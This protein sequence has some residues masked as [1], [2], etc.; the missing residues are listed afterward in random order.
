MI[1]VVVIALYISA[2]LSLIGSPVDVNAENLPEMIVSRFKLQIRENGKTTDNYIIGRLIIFGSKNAPQIVWH[3]VL[4][5]T[6]HKLKITSVKSSYADS[7]TGE[8]KNLIIGD[9]FFSFNFY[10]NPRRSMMIVGRRREPDKWTE[11][12]LNYFKSEMYAGN[13]EIEAKGLWWSPILNDTIEMEWVPVDEIE[14]IYSKL[15]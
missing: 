4:L 9:D 8:I 3:D 12:G 14:L 11:K 15:E 6:D 1:R 5:G 13:F 7:E 10:L 2:C